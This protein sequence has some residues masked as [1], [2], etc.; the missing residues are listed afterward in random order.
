MISVPM[1]RSPVAVAGSLLLV[2]RNLNCLNEI[3]G[4]GKLDS[5]RCCCCGFTTRIAFQQTAPS[6]CEWFITT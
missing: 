3:E 5:C 1:L 4:F 2:A 6:P